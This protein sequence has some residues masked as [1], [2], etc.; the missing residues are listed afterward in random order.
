MGRCLRLGGTIEA[1][2]R[3]PRHRLN[4]FGT[5]PGAKLRGHLEAGGVVSMCAVISPNA[6]RNDQA[7]PVTSRPIASRAIV[8]E[9]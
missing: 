8:K 5:G 3:L 4:P 9:T 1:V 2:T 6:T 7:D